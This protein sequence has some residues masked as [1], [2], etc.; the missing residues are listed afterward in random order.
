MNQL[1]NE[2]Y[3]LAKKYKNLMNTDLS[4][5]ILLLKD[6]TAASLKTHG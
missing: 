4:S 5:K 3:A 6:S 1:E 2:R